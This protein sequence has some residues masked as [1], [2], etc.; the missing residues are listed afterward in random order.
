MPVGISQENRPFLGRN[1][2]ETGKIRKCKSGVDL[3]QN[4]KKLKTESGHPYLGDSK[5]SAWS[6]P[7]LLQSA[8]VGRS[9]DCD[10][11]N[12]SHKHMMG[13]DNNSTLCGQVSV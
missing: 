9:S 8:C 2:A 5:N 1:R 10:S 7:R 3:P 12:E 13:I 4:A 11:K 6:S